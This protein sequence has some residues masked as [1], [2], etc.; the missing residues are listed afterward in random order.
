MLKNLQSLQ[1]YELK[2]KRDTTLEWIKFKTLTVL[3][4]AEDLEQLKL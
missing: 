4:G 3:S 1:K 2:L